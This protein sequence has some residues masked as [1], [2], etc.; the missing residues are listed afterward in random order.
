MDVTCIT[1]AEILMMVRALASFMISTRVQ[2]VCID[3]VLISIIRVMV[4]I[5]GL[6]TIKN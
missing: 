3:D 1:R 2:H 5:E 6:D 4:C